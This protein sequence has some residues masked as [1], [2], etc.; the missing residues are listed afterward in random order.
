MA[1]SHSSFSQPGLEVVQP[2]I[3]LYAMPPRPATAASTSSSVSFSKELPPI[4]VPQEPAHDAGQ[5]QRK[6]TKTMMGLSVPV[7]WCLVVVLIILLGAGI[8]GGVGA[9]LSAQQ[10][11]TS[12]E[13]VPSGMGGTVIPISSLLTAVPSAP[14]APPAPSSSPDSALPTDGGCP[15]IDNLGYS[16]YS[17]DG[18]P[19]PAADGQ[20]PQEFREQCFTNWANTGAQHDIMTTYTPTLEECIVVCAEY[21]RGYEQSLSQHVDVGG[22]PCVAVTLH[23]VH[24]GFCYLKNGTGTNDTLGTPEMYSSAVLISQP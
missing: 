10:K 13:V 23:K 15:A 21:N 9:G 6:Q 12:K 1:S 4:V 17:A 20:Q 19:I 18:K 5:P 3:G 22:G 24:A 11:S 7:F 8:G 14:S 2:E 16:A